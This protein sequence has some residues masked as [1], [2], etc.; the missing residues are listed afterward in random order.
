MES[1]VLSEPPPNMRVQRTRSSASPPRL[2]LTRGPL[3]AGRRRVAAV[4]ALILGTVC[5]GS[6]RSF[7]SGDEA[8]VREALSKFVVSLNNLDWETFRTCFSADVTLFNPEI[9]EV[10]KLDRID[11][12]TGVE[13]SFRAVFASA[14]QQAAGPP[15]LH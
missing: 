3:G 5:C 7:Q 4:A 15:Y 2:P 9:P 8:A 14:R 6:G 10:S 12:K 13:A 1:G 11:G